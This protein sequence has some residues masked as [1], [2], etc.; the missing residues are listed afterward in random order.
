MIVA[1]RTLPGREYLLSAIHRTTARGADGHLCDQVISLSRDP[2][3]PAVAPASA[4]DGRIAA[5]GA[6]PDRIPYEASSAASAADGRVSLLAVLHSRQLHLS[7]I[8]ASLLY[9]NPHQQ[10]GKILM[11]IRIT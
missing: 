2:F 7:G 10:F 8:D 6:V 5:T 4:P 1:P 3:F 9:K 11:K